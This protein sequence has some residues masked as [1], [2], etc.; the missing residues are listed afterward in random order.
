MLTSEQRSEIVENIEKRLE[1]SEKKAGAE[2]GR[3]TG[4]DFQVYFPWSIGGQ[5]H[6]Q[7]DWI[8][9]YGKNAQFKNM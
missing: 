3:S 5:F 4:I 7:P 1:H 9:S 8:L 2:N 6:Y